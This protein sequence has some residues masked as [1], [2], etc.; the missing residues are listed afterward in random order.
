MD[1]IAAACRPRGGSAHDRSR[2]TCDAN[3]YEPQVRVLFGTAAHLCKAVDLIG[4]LFSTKMR[5]GSDAGLYVKRIDFC[6]SQLQA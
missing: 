2:N 1:Y 6:I 5:S 4:L 3:V